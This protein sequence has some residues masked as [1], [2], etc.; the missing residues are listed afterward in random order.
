MTPDIQSLLAKNKETFDKHSNQRI[1]ILGSGPSVNDCDLTLLHDEITIAVNQFSFHPDLERIAPDYYVTADPIGYR[2]DEEGGHLSLTLRI[3]DNLKILENKPKIFLPLL[4][5]SHLAD[6][7]QFKI[8]DVNWFLYNDRKN[9]SQRID[10]SQDIPT[11]GQNILNIALMLA[12]HL[13]ASEIYLVG[14]DNG[15]V[16]QDFVTTHFY[17]ALGHEDEAQSRYTLSDLERCMYTHLNQ[18]NRLKRYAENRGITIF[19]TAKDGSFKLF[20][21]V[22]YSSLFRSMVNASA[23]QA[24]QLLKQG[25]ADEAQAQLQRLAKLGEYPKGYH[26]LLAEAYRLQNDLQGSKDMLALEKR[27]YPDN[28]SA[29]TKGITAVIHQHIEQ[30]PSAEC[31]SIWQGG[32]WHTYSRGDFWRQMQEYAVLFA[33]HCPPHSLVLFI[34]RTDMDLLAAYL[35][36]IHADMHPAQLSPQSGKISVAEYQRKLDHL[37]K[38]TGAR[39]LFTDVENTLPQIENVRILTRES[40]RGP[41]QTIGTPTSEIALAQFSSGSTGLQKAV[42]LSHKALLEHMHRYGDFIQLSEND[43]LI[44]WLPLYHDMGLIACYLMPLMRGVP[45]MIMDPFDWIA[46]PQ[47]LLDAITQYHCTLCYLPNFAYHVLANKGKPTDL[48]S[49]RLFINCSEPA[50]PATHRTFLQKFSSLREEQL[51]VCYA[52]AENTFAVSQTPVGKSALVYKLHDKEILSCGT[53]I[54]GTEV[55]ILNPD[56]DGVGEVAIRGETLY[57]HFLDGQ[58]QS[59]DGFY[60]TGDLGMMRDG[61]LFI[62]GRIKDLIIVNGKNIYPQDVEH[63]VSNVSGVYPGRCVCFGVDSEA[64]GSER[65]VVLAELLD[66]AVLPDTDKKIRAAVLAETGIAPDIVELVPYMT[67]VK[68]SSGKISRSRNKERYLQRKKPC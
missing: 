37:L 54:D 2:A 20:P 33:S 15:G 9:E 45:F 60:P 50:K 29:R 46:K 7:P 14:F 19:T 44:S 5:A 31:F 53:L 49:V 58:D 28:G 65:L 39:F 1:F 43:R 64:S 57:S 26:Q 3:L 22:R 32:T 41:L 59:V 36:A 68:T 38:V 34:K 51:A 6:H 66:D 21:Y 47:R 23:S 16:V 10:F 17:N 42:F 18:L 48:S 13:G 35:G 52:L 12:F 63:A 67:L 24:K 55:N 40:K 61:E 62:T 8:H 30:D 4:S 56:T 11:F 27:L 25:K